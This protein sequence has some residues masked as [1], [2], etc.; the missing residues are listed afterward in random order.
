MIQLRPYQVKA[1]EAFEAG[2]AAG[3]K[4]LIICCPTGT[5]KTVTG[6][7][8]AKRRGPRLLWLTHREELIDQT[9]RECKAIWPEA[10]PGIVMGEL[11]QDHMDAVFASVQTLSRRNRFDSLLDT[12]ARGMAWPFNL[13]IVDE[14]HHATSQTY[15]RLLEW[16][17]CPDASGAHTG[18]P[19]LGLTATVE[20]GD[21]QGLDAAFEGIAYKMEL[22]DAIR[23]GYLVNCRSIP[24]RLPIDWSKVHIRHGDF[25][26]DELADELIR[27]GAAEATAL[28]IGAHARDRRSIIFCV[29]VNQAERTTAKLCEIGVKAET[30]SGETPTEQ[31]REIVA[32]FRSGEIEAMSNCSL[33]IEGFD[34]PAVS[35]IVV[36]R[37]TRSKLLYHQIIGRGLR[38]FPGKQDCLI[39]DL[40]GAG[41]RHGLIQASDLLG[42]GVPT[43]QTSDSDGLADAKPQQIDGELL[44]VKGYLAA[45]TSAAARQNVNWVQIEPDSLFALSAPGATLLLVRTQDDF[46]HSWT[47][48]RKRTEDGRFQSDPWK[49]TDQGSVSLELAQG[50]GEDHA[51]KLGAFKLASRDAV[52]RNGPMSDK[53]RIAL[54]KWRVPIPQDRILSSGEASDMLLVKTA[55]VEVARHKLRG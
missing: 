16:L 29:S 37:P 39:L 14:V 47:I 55:K 43:P 19:V 27:A 26:Q 46:W 54:E 13:V 4:R 23:Q 33:F 6:L 48:G 32:K 24:I 17:G 42:T 25:A 21:G 3:Q 9:I 7:A 41:D 36:A 50:I 18:P 45:A 10:R 31:R 49:L 40:V 34:S 28:A 2:I 12:M 20:R 15:A 8:A 38:T 22:L 51:R 53:Q 52:W 44:L 1:V 30:V 35:C 5:G 11:G